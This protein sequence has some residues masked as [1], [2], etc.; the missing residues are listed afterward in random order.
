MRK[1]QYPEEF[2]K[3]VGLNLTTAPRG[4]QK[5]TANLLGVSSRTLRSWK[6][7]HRKA[8]N[9]RGRK[10]LEV[11]L[12]EVFA[13][14]RE[15]LRQGRPGSR[16]VIY[17]LPQLRIKVVRSVIAEL[18]HRYKKRYEKIKVQERKT[19][20]V[21]KP[22]FVTAMDGATITK[23][24]D[25]IVYRDRGSISTN[26]EECEN[27]LRANDTLRVLTKLKDNNRLP[28]V[29][30]TDNGSPLCAEV[31]KDFL[32]EN[33]VIHLRSLP[34]VP[35]Q[36]GSA[37]NAV[38][39]FKKLV[40]S[41]SSNEAACLILNKHRKRQKLG[42]KTSDEIEQENLVLCKKEDRALFFEATRTAIEIAVLGIDSAHEKRKA[43]RNAI[44]ETM[45]RFSLITITRGQRHA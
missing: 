30:C 28:L 5:L 31:V 21:H 12:L 37:E 22:G 2:K 25:V 40:K 44:F 16:P 24:E 29:L 20:H 7:D 23:G 26:I 19:M 15:W 41:G 39:D 13:I 35:Q 36:N 43:E 11:T 27:H 4:T 1:Q 17:A 14:T 9:K 32:N 8:Y 42:Y 38:Q 18:K 34:R 10:K 6:K 45:E 33:H 3:R